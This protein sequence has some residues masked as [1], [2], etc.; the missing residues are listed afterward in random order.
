MIGSRTWLPGCGAD[1]RG[2]GED[3][4]RCEVGEMTDRAERVAR[5]KEMAEK[6]GYHLGTAPDAT[7]LLLKGHLIVEEEI[8]YA[9]AGIFPNSEALHEARLTFFQKLQ[10]M[11]AFDRLGI[12]EQAFTAAEKLNRIRNRLAHQLEPIGIEDAIAAFVEDIAS[13]PNTTIEP[14]DSDHLKFIRCIIHVGSQLDACRALYK[15]LSDF[16][17]GIGR[18]LPARKVLTEIA[19]LIR[20]TIRDDG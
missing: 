18:G 5:D 4:D 3:G 14:D 7:V 20:S 13:W 6:I 15:L 9:L 1:M 10:L 2:A 11:R 19:K 8:N 12:A 17:L 16:E